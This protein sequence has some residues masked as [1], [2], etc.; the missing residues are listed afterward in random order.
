MAA[1]REGD[2]IN[3]KTV[4]D[5][6]SGG[7]GALR[8]WT[9]RG[10]QTGPVTLAEGPLVCNPSLFLALWGAEEKGGDA[11]QNSG[12]E[13]LDDGRTG[14]P[15]TGPPRAPTRQVCARAGGAAESS[16]F[17]FWVL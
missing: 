9:T 4:A 15:E 13:K 5:A 17:P 16:R 2:P 8:W 7:A 12:W 3:I 6:P 1:E 10:E 14:T 11:Y